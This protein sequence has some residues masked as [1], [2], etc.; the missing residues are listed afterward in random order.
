MQILRKKYAFGSKWPVD[1]DRIHSPCEIPCY[2]SKCNCQRWAR[3]FLLWMRYCYSWFSTR[4]F[5]RRTIALFKNILP[6]YCRLPPFLPSKAPAQHSTV[7]PSEEICFFLIEG[8]PIT[9]NLKVSMN[10]FGFLVADFAI[11]LF[12]MVLRSC[13]FN[14]ATRSSQKRNI[15]GKKRTMKE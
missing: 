9:S 2:H 13:A 3:A 6:R 4:P 11:S 1:Y 14:L 8:P 15:G 7:K 5:A 12:F 10:Y